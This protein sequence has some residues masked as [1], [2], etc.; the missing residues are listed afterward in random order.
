MADDQKEDDLVAKD[1]KTLIDNN[2][3]HQM[4][5]MFGFLEN[6]DRSEFNPSE[7]C[8]SFRPNGEPVNVAIQ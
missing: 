5:K 6:S 4:Q 1:P 2:L 8:F 7:F 3:L